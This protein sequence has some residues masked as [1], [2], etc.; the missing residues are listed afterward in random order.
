MNPAGNEN[1][2]YPIRLGMWTNWSRGQ[3]MGSTLTLQRRDADLLIA[4]IGFLIAFFA[5]RAWRILCFV[6]HR[7]YSTPLPQDAIYHQHQAILRN[8]SSPEDGINLLLRLLWESRH[9]KGRLRP[10]STATV[11]TCCLTVFTI[12][13][14]FSSRIS[15]GIGNEVLISSNH[16]GSSLLTSVFDDPEKYFAGLPYRAGLINNAANYALQCYSSNISVGLNCDRYVKKHITG[17]VD[18][19]APCPFG[20]RICRNETLNIRLDSGYV[21]SHE[22]LGVNSPPDQRVLW[23]NVLQCG[24]LTTEG[25]TSEQNP[26]GQNETFTLYHYGNTTGVRGDPLDY[27][28][29]AASVESQYSYILT[30]TD[31]IDTYFTHHLNPIQSTVGNRT[32]RKN[33]DFEPIQPL[34]QNDADTYIIFLSGNGVQYSFPTS[35]EW[36][37]VAATPSNGSSVSADTASP[38]KVYLPLQPASPLGCADQYQFCNTALPEER[39]CGPLA[40]LLDAIS[41]AAPLFGTQYLN[42]FT[43]GL[44][45]GNAKT[46]SEARFNYFAS[47]FG[48]RTSINILL[49]QLGSMGLIS[50]RNLLGGI[51]GPLAPNQWQL[52]ISHLWNI[53]MALQQVALIDMAYGPTDPGTLQ[54]WINFT[55]PALQKICGSQK[56]HSTAYGS[57]SV[58]GLCFTLLFGF[59]ITLISFLL[60]PTSRYLCKKKGYKPYTHLEW[61]TNATLQLQRL[62][63]DEVG[64]GT[65]SQCIQQIPHTKANELLACLDITDPTHPVLYSAAHK[66]TEVEKPHN[67]T[68]CHD[69]ISPSHS[70]PSPDMSTAPT[71][72]TVDLA[73]AL[74]TPIE[75]KI[76]PNIDSESES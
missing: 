67:S 9:S 27:V 39:R 2:Q 50:Q 7:Y 14:G 10:L 45:A 23:R 49:T 58:F 21:D 18:L 69:T 54:T 4:F 16:C 53:T 34:F 32:T 48:T 3:I 59:L 61:T 30:S 47:R 20:D 52:D 38:N 73:T 42:Y 46:E 25:F 63:Y 6:F 1:D 65:W 35:D 12:A 37:Q 36:Y 68:L 51:Q 19:E 56:I 62:A 11:A 28:Y 74:H 29:R 13:G 22:D 43:S 33:S 66:E 44:N 64:S 70:R 31:I 15:T 5:T 55:S 60:E 57:F 41:G 71:S 72:E 26:A 24:P 76:T 40:S 75:D 8:S 17:T